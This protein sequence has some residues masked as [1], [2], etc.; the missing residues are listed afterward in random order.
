MMDDS[1]HK[2]KKKTLKKGSVKVA[3]RRSSV[4]QVENVVSTIIDIEKGF[5]LLDVEQTEKIQ[6]AEKQKEKQMEE[7]RL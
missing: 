3:R 1:A 2:M 6:K 7:R 5:L 4:S